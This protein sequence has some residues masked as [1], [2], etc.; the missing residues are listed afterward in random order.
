MKMG[1]QLWPES[2][3]GSISHCKQQVVAVAARVDAVSCVGIDIEN[4]HRLS[5]AAVGAL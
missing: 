1:C 5:Q 4:M 3:I 2:Y